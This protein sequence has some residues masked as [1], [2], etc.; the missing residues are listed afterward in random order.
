MNE[1]EKSKDVLIQ[2][3]NALRD[4]ISKLETE[5]DQAEKALVVSKEIY[6]SIT[7]DV[8]DSSRVG[9]VILDANFRVVWVNQSLTR[10]F[11]LRIE[12]IIGKQKKQLIKDRL[13][14]IFAQPDVYENRILATYENN[15]YI[16]SL[17]CQILADEDREERWLELWSRPIRSGLYKGGRIEHYTDITE[18][19][20]GE[21]FLRIAKEYSDRLINSSTDIII[22]VDLERK[23]IEFNKAA[24][25]AFGYAKEEVLGKHVDILY[26]DPSE[27]FFVYDKT[28]KEGNYSKEITNKKKNG[29]PF[30]V[31]LSASVMY[32]NHD[33]PL[34]LMGISR[35]VVNN[36]QLESERLKAQKLESI[37]VLAGGI[38]H[39]FNNL[40]TSIIG[41]IALVKTSLESQNHQESVNAL[42]MAKTASRRAQDL[43]QKLL[44]FAKGGTPIRKVIPAAQLLRDTVNFVVSKS[45]VERVT[46]IPDDLPPTMVDKEQI[47]VVMQNL[48]TNGYEAMPDGGTLSI[49][50][51]SVRLTKDKK[52]PLANGN[53]IK[54]TV[55]DTG[56]GIPID[57]IQ[58]VFD[59]FFTTKR[60]NSGLGLATAYSITR[61]HEGFITV[62]SEV[63]KGSEFY[64]YLPVYEKDSPIKQTNKSTTPCQSKGKVLILDDEECITS[65]ASKMLVRV[66]YLVETAHTGEQ[67]IELFKQA[68]DRA[69][70]FDIVILDLAITGGMGGK[71]TIHRLRQEDPEIK[72][73][74]S[75]GYYDDPIMSNFKNSGFD[76]VVTKPYTFAALSNAVDDLMAFTR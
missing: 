43:T 19:K 60:R 29:E 20:Q 63:G 41:S 14:H 9:V 49:D 22:S 71:E 11:G 12:E 6:R 36:K 13:K 65:V 61:K 75:S 68:K 17:E 7:D 28:L 74:V 26:S 31:Y 73:I 35:H 44:T 25:Q 2:E 70:P 52:L 64:V 3:L 27:G 54:V 53:Y 39:D 50:A 5:Y 33:N 40:L 23:I 21:L 15:T 32:D 42:E 58:K 69:E 51:Q 30:K 67:A 57:Q 24:Q 18:R 45:A 34:G 66:G 72:A 10:Y 62:Q 56:F 38:A 47:R 16:E 8:L 76:G 1:R 46:D 37:G 59:P 55:K 4:R 48:I